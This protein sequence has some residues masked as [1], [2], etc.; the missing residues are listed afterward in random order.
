MTSATLVLSCHV[1]SK[2]VDCRFVQWQLCVFTV[3]VRMVF[4]GVHASRKAG[5]GMVLQ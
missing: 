5:I 4:V 2:I 3:N 1:V